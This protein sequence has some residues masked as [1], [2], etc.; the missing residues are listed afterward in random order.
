MTRKG[1]VQKMEE[2]YAC[3]NIRGKRVYNCKAW[4]YMNTND[5]VVALAS[6]NTLVAVLWRGIV[7]EFGRYSNTTSC[8]VRKF[9]CFV[10]SPVVSLYRT[11][12]MGKRDY[13]THMACDWQDVIQVAIEGL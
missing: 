2:A 11:S 13:T 5:G 7:W 1:L 9:A 12:K 6:Y 4:W 8:H 3:G 10:G